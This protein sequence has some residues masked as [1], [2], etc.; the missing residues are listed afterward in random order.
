LLE[1]LK[2]KP[3]Q[4]KGPNPERKPEALDWIEGVL[5]FEDGDEAR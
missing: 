3:A 5:A 1:Q 4:A 2:I